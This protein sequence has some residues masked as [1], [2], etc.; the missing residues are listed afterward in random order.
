MIYF[1]QIPNKKNKIGCSKNVSKRLSAL[2]SMY[3][4]FPFLLG[5]MEGGREA[6]SRDPSPICPSPLRG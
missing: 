1:V 6:R 3:G 5:I 2:Y 4:G